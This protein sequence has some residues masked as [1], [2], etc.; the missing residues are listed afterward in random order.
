MPTLTIFVIQAAKAQNEF[1]RNYPD[2]A[3]A[4]RYAEVQQRAAMAAGLGPGGM[5]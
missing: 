3:E 2:I 5:L 4:Y 1:S